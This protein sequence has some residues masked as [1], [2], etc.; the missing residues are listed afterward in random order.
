[1]KN[2]D[3]WVDPIVEEVRRIRDEHAARF[4]YDIHRI[5]EDVRREQELDQAGGVEY[6]TLKPRRPTAVAS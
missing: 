2:A 3:T 5:C 6:V 4:D 1:M